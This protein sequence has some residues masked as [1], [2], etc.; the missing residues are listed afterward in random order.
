MK[1][2]LFILFVLVMITGLFAETTIAKIPKSTTQAIT[3]QPN[4]SR[5]YDWH[6]YAVSGEEDMLT[7][8]TPERATFFE[9]ADFCVAGPVTIEQ[10]SHIFYEHESYPWPD[11]SF[12]FKIYDA[13]GSTLLHESADLEAENY[14]EYFYTLPA[15][16]VVDGDFYVAIAS[17][18]VSG[19]PSSMM[20]SLHS[21]H[22][23]N[24]DATEW[25]SYGYEYITGVYLEGGVSGPVLNVTPSSY[26]F[27]NV[28]VGSSAT[29]TF[30]LE[31]L[32]TGDI[33]LGPA[34]VLIG[35]EAFTISADTG[36]PYPTTIPADQ[37]TIEIEVE[38]APVVIGPLS[39]VLN[40]YDDLTRN[41]TEINISGYGMLTTDC[42]WYIIG[43]DAYGDGWNG[44]SIDV[45]IDGVTYYNFT[46]ED[47]TGP[48]TF[49]FGVFD[50]C[51]IDLIW[52]PGAYDEEITYTLYNHLD[53]VIFSDGPFPTGTTGIA[54][55]CYA[56]PAFDPP[57]NVTINDELGTLSWF[58]PTGE[59]IIDD[60][61]DSYTAGN[62]LA[63]V[64]ADWTTWSGT[65]GGGDDAYITNEQALSPDNSVV[66]EGASD[67]VLIMDD[68]TEGV[69]IVDFDLY[70]P[71]GFCGYWNLQ[72]TSTPGQE[73]GFQVQFDATGTASADAGGEASLVYAF[74]FDT[75]IHQKIIVDLDNDIAYY[76]VD[77]EFMID[78]QWSTG[79]FGDPGLVQLG[80]MN[81]YA[82]A[83]AGNSPK[84]YFDNVVL[85][86]PADVSGYNV[87]LNYNL[88][89]ASPLDADVTE[90]TYSDLNDGQTYVAGVSALYDGVETA[91]VEIEFT[92]D[93][94]DNFLPPNNPAAVV[95]DYNDVLVTWELPGGAVEE[96]AHHTGYDANGIGTGAP[97]DF[98]CAAR[99][100]AVELADYYG[101]WEITGVNIV[102]NSLDFSYVG[103]QVYE[104]GSIGDPG[105]LVYEE[106][107]TSSAV[108][109]EWTPHLLTTPVPLVAGNEY[110]LAYD[111][112]ATGE[113]PAG[114]DAG[115][116]VPDKGAWMYFGGAWQTL[117]ELGAT[118]DFNWVI[119]GM[120]SQSD[121]VASK[122]T[123]QSE[124]I[125]RTH[126]LNSRAVFEAEF[127]YNS[128][129]VATTQQRDSRSLAG[130]KVFRDGAEIAVITDPAI[131][132]FLDECLDAG[133]YE[134][135]I[136]AYYTNPEGESELTNPVDVTI[137]LDPPSNGNAQSQPPNIIV[138]WSAPA[139][140]V[141]NYNVYRDGVLHEEGVTGLMFIDITV[142]TGDYIYNLTAV[143]C[144]GWESEFGPD[145]E[146]P[147]V[148]GD[149]ILKPT[150]T[151]LTGNYPNPFNPTT[152]IS[153]SLKE[154]GHVSINI[155]NM[156]GQL[157]KTLVN[158]ELDRN[159]HNIVWDGKDNSGKNTS[160]G[161][162][163]YKMK[164]QN[165]NSTKKMILMK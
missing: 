59:A 47:G 62:Q 128:R 54:A 72:K 110:W 129:R 99:F 103:I 117:P 15:P 23:Y 12:H 4:P 49:N 27:G 37:T 32:C 58:A 65:P 122:G 142:P 155:Y 145:L 26:Y 130:Y 28:D 135:T 76:Y 159:F 147:H 116:M 133:T 61:F 40:I 100:D 96:I 1:K 79:C 121:A 165:Y 113:Y 141:D 78:Y 156:R 101:G 162:Y 3:E 108:A 22:S 125:G 148:D 107:V 45:V 14:V 98:I 43:E 161:V 69:C 137:V 9:L 109:G 85:A 19:H 7:W 153:F 138:T 126:T 163:F 136:M 10:V 29:Q 71:T 74:D 64:G 93:P 81:L 90:F 44:G 149:D 38:F 105:T 102:L 111:I 120:V 164:T 60:D 84:C 144:G 114:V 97:A 2:L 152:K 33:V 143:Y 104:G 20:T 158:T 57:E 68:Y 36:S 55:D 70:I 80:G 106:D 66:V 88:D 35:D 63:L 118:L 34:P 56:P 24:G 86:Q 91:I 13:D 5:D 16:L 25:F 42:D 48:E 51:T 154:A 94:D 8:T 18:D 160:S 53:E 139:R 67:L 83:S 75:W 140:G 115:P 131:L 30:V 21:G 39:T 73:W 127:A 31:R 112:Q 95:E 17:V 52:N 41:T 82:W 46:I 132:S 50:P 151:E 6:A 124:I 157:V 87:Y 77:G 119:T 150:V 123:K 92:Y 134:Y 11:A 89:P 146:V